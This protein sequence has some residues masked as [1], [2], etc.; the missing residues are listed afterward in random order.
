M[1]D[2]I[3]TYKRRSGESFIKQFSDSTQALK[4]RLR[5]EAAIDD[6]DIE[7]A[8]ISA[9]SL[10]SLK[11]SHSRYFM[12]RVEIEDDQVNAA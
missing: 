2:F 3:I 7:I 10:E 12:G 1:T 6:P 8:H 11:K 5:R 9:P 4:E